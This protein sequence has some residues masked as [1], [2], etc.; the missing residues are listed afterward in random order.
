MTRGSTVT[1]DLVVLVLTWIKTFRNW[2][3]ARRLGI[4]L[5]VSECLLRDGEYLCIIPHACLH[6]N[7]L[8][9][10]QERGT[11][12]ESDSTR[13]QVHSGLTA[14]SACVDVQGSTSNEHRT[15]ADIQ[16]FPGML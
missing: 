2:S 14:E 8:N 4:E 16:H 10:V 7:M 1:A 13:V 9:N 3:E 11:S 15:N 6:I 5:T 12:C